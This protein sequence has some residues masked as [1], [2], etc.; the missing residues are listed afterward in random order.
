MT[1]DHRQHHLE[2]VRSGLSVALYPMQYAVNLPFVIGSWASESLAERKSLIDENRALKQ[3]QLE[4]D[5]RLLKLAALENENARLRAMLQSAERGWERVLI[6]QLLAVDSDP[7]KRLVV[8]DKGSNNGIK[9]GHP[10]IDAHGVLGQV[11]HVSRFTSTAILLTDPTHAIPVQVN[12]NG[13]RAIA[14]G[15]NAP[16]KLEIPHIPINA[17]I[18]VGDLLVTSG[19][20]RRF[21]AGY[22]VAI[23]SEIV[24]D[25]SESYAHVT[26]SPLAHLERSREVLLVWPSEDEFEPGSEEEERK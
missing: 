4:Q 24:I 23:I 17:D 5:I 8:L 13:L 20:G 25:P 7:F 21:P 11:Q 6:A 10:I 22:P 18:R 14:L 16:D 2:N 19:L 26:A 12:R 15:S 1:L 9:E 3:Y